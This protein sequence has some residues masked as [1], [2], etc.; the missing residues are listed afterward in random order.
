MRIFFI[1]LTIFFTAAIAS[2]QSITLVTLGDSLTFG[3][4]DETA[5]GGYPARLIKM[6]TFPGWRIRS[7]FIMTGF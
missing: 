4:G 1:F 5:A 2:G 3:D 7:A 6:P